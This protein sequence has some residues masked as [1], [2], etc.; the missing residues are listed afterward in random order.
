MLTRNP[1]RGADRVRDDDRAF[2]KE[3][4]FEIVLAS[5]DAARFEAFFESVGDGLVS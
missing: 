5:K 3:R 1:G 4:L 2:R